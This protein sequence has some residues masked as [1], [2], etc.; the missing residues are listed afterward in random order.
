MKILLL[1]DANSI[2][3]QKW[4]ESLNSQGVDIQLFSLFKPS[5]ITQRKFY[6]NKIKVVSANLESEIKD[7]RNPNLS[8]LRYF[9]SLLIVKK[10]IKIF[11][12]DIVHAHYASSYGV[13]GY[14]SNFRPFVLSVWGS[15]ISYFPYKN[16]FNKILMKLVLRNCDRLC[17]TSNYMKKIIEK[18]YGVY[19]VDIIPFGVDVEVFQPRLNERKSFNVGT[20]KSIEDHNGVD[21]LI[22]AAKIITH[23]HKKEI[24]FLIVGDGSLMN[25]MQQKAN[26]LNLSNNV[27]FAGFIDHKNI[28]DQYKKLSI[29]VVAS[30]RE[31]FGVSV[32]EAAACEIPTITTGIGGLT[33]VNVHNSTGLIIKENSPIELANSILHLYEN[34]ELRKNLGKNGRKRVLKYF[35]WENNVLDM[36]KLYKNVL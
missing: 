25:K 29:F 32:L 3:T 6:K 12:P 4:V 16:K 5:K 22:E 11:S 1:S 26:E 20:I 31:S 10:M 9:K 30:E 34:K 23:D 19:D 36:I 7:L 2:H 13:L 8:K 27:N 35:N 21:C 14:L 15:D 28:I 33:E 24:N 18:E 17:S